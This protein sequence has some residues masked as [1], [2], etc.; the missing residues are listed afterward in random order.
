[1]V[2]KFAVSLVAISMLVVLAPHAD[3]ADNHAGCTV[4]GVVGPTPGVAYAPQAGTYDIKGY[5]DCMSDG[6]NHGTLVGTGTGTIGC[7]GGYSTAALKILWEGDKT[8]TLTLQLGDFTYGTGGGGTVDDGEYKGSHVMVGWGRYSAGA[9][10]RCGTGGV[11]SYEFAG[12]MM[13]G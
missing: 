8:S 10:M 3:A 4:A 5:I 13:I 12:G 7:L 11:K 1:M 6:A 9:E 2:R